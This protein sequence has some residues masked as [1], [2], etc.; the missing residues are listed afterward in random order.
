MRPHAYHTTEQ[1]KAKG[2][3]TAIFFLSVCCYDYGLRPDWGGSQIPALAAGLSAAFE[4]NEAADASRRASTSQLASA[5]LTA[6]S[7][8][9][10]SHS[11]YHSFWK[12]PLAA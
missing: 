1:T 11:K 6:A 2:K 10:N 7:R 9:M 5:A 12:L 4:G 3:V 8:A